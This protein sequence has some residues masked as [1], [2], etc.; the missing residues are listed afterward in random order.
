MEKDYYTKEEVDKL[1]AD[2]KK[3]AREEGLN[4]GKALQKAEDKKIADQEREER[5]AAEKKKKLEEEEA[6]KKI[7]KQ[8]S[9]EEA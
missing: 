5:L 2:A 4:E 3:K 1:L 9:M 8:K 7:A 6:A